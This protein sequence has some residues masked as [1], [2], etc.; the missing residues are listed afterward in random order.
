MQHSSA[1]CSARGRDHDAPR[2]G[3]CR[4]RRDSVL[5]AHGDDELSAARPSHE[6]LSSRQ[7]ARTPA[8]LCSAR[9][10]RH[11]RVAAAVELG[12][13]RQRRRTRARRDL[14]GSRVFHASSA[15]DL[16]AVGDARRQGRERKRVRPPRGA[17]RSRAWISSARRCGARAAAGG[18]AVGASASQVVAV[19]AQDRQRALAVERLAVAGDDVVGALDERL[20]PVERREVGLERAARSPSI[21]ISTGERWSPRDEHAAPTATR[22]PCRRRCGRRR[23]AAR[24][25]ASPSPQLR[26]APAAPAASRA[27]AARGARRSA[28]RRSRA[29][30]AAPRPGSSRSRRAVDSRDA[31]AARPGTRAAEQVVPVGVRGQQPDDAEARLLGDGRQQLELVGQDRRVEQNASSPARTSVHVVW[32]K[33]RRR[34]DDVGVEPRRP[35][36]AHSAE[37]LGRLLEVLDLF[38]RLLLRRSSSSPVAVDPDRRGPWASRTARCRGSSS[39]PRGPSPSWRR[40]GARTP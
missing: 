14:H 13:V 34:D 18:C 38:G 19:L 36:P 12:A 7:R 29:A 25:P 35:S 37:E 26:R 39:T 28:R 4:R 15:P 9:S 23:R 40:C 33:P 2:A 22:S 17:R 16:L 27:P 20:E 11:E 31:R 30:R 3:A 6:L 10:E 8:Q 32:Q 5:D 24:A 1:S 21:G